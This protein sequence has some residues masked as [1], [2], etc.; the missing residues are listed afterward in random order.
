MY[1]LIKI[2]AKLSGNDFPRGRGYCSKRGHFFDPLF[3][4][5]CCFEMKVSELGDAENSTRWR[6]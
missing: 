3:R 4:Q 5:P 2:S 1:I 6:A